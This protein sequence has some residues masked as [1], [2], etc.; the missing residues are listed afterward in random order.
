[1]QGV[2]VGHVLNPMQCR[3]QVE[4][5]VA[6]AI[7]WALTEKM[8]FD[9]EGRLLNPTFRHYRIPAFADVPRTEVHFADT[10][11]AFGPFGAK[12]V[13]EGPFNCVAPA[14]ANAVADATGVRFRS[15]PLAPDRIYHDISIKTA[16]DD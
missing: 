14:L 2:D 10:V 7:G 4:G 6:Q 8:V 12:S 16:S 9:D 3:G 13:G 15:L 11:D 1:V 5:A